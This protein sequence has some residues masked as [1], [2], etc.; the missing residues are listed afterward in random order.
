MKSSH[1]HFRAIINDLRRLEGDELVNEFTRIFTTR[2]PNDIHDL[3]EAREKRDFTALKQKSHFLST[4][5]LTLKFNQGLALTNELQ[6]QT[7]LGE[8]TLAL[9]LSDQLIN[10]LNRALNELE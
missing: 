5:L 7:A 2:I 4:T 3:I 1:D 9:D 10:Y 6:K 8:E